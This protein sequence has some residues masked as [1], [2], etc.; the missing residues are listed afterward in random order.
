M[1][2]PGFFGEYSRMDDAIAYV[3]YVKG[4]VRAFKIKLIE[5]QNSGWIDLAAD[6]YDRPTS[7]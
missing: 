1:Q 5:E 6:W 3:E 2:P 4:K 7:T